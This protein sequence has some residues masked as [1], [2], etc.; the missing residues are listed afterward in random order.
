MNMPNRI[1][2]Q[3]PRLLTAPEFAWLAAVP[4][5]AQWFVNLDSAQT[6][7]AYQSDLRALMVF[8][9]SCSPKNFAASRA[10]TS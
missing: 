9:A 1:S 5:E 3:G 8:P 6:R 2:L 10:A 4:P 7:R